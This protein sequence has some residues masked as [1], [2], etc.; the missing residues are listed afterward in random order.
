MRPARSLP[1]EALATAPN[2]PPQG[3]FDTDAIPRIPLSRPGLTP[4]KAIDK[5][6]I[7]SDELRFSQRKALPFPHRYVV[8]LGCNMSKSQWT[9]TH[10]GT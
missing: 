1:T 7:A 3:R 6:H 8:V 5:T 4:P 10:T 2:Y 9:E